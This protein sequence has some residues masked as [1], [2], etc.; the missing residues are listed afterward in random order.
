MAYNRRSKH[1][2]Q[3]VARSPNRS[4]YYALGYQKD[5]FDKPM[6][7]IANGHS[8]ITPCNSGLQRLSD[9]AVAAVKAAD[10]NPQIFGTPTIS[11]GMSM[12]TE[13]MKYSLVS[14]EVIADC[15]ET[16]VQGQW[17]DGVVVVG[18]CDKNMPGGMIALAR[19][20]VPGIYVYGGT[21]RPGN[22]KGRDLTIV[23]SFEAVGEF[24]A[25]RMSQE[26]FEGVEQNACPTSGSCGGMYTANTMSSSF[27][28]LG[29]SL[30][31]SSTM[32]NPDQEKV[33]SAAESARVL[34]EAVKRDLKPRD[35]ITKASIENAVSVIMAT[36]GST[37]AVLHYLAIAHAAE[38]DWTIEDFERIRKRV[39]VICDLKPSGKYVATDLHRAGGIPQVLKILLDAGLLHG[40]CT[41]ITG[42]TLADELK[43]VPSVPRADQDVIFPINRALYKEGHL[44]ILKGNLAEDGAVAKITGLKNPVITGPARVFDDEQSAMDAILGDRIRAGDILVLRYLGPKGGPGMPEMLAPTSAIIGKGLGESVGFITDGRFSGGTWGMVVGHVA[45]E[46]FVGGTIALVQEGDSITIDAH[47]LLLQ[48]NV[49]DAELARRRAAWQQPAPRYTRGVLAKFAALARPANQGAVTG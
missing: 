41:T 14:R 4:M 34:V 29:M 1:I 20:N 44:A 17:M 7:G 3:G 42:R 45:P 33:D 25:G 26:D 39:P 8:T 48:L 9:A 46:A 30:L 13:G 49:D 6:I 36:G 22:W 28:A 18:G 40:D 38:V 16:C 37:N 43:D 19:L 12:G 24:T 32:A 10:A 35:I 31:Y 21:I 5:D 2:T 27:E 47:Q 23:S 11:D 15:I